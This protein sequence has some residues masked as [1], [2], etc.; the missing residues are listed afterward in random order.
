VIEVVFAAILKQLMLAYPGLAWASIWTQI[1]DIVDGMGPGAR[2]DFNR[3]WM[4]EMDVPFPGMEPQ[5]NPG[6]PYDPGKV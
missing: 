5:E 1:V 3:W 4:Q 6:E 2:E